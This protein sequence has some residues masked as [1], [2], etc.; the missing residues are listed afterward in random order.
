[1]EALRYEIDEKGT[2]YYIIDK[3]G[4]K[5]LYQYPPYI[6]YEK[7]T[8]EES[9]QAHIE[10]MEREAQVAEQERITIEDLQ[11]QITELKKTNEELKSINSEQDAL[12]AELV[13]I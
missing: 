4:K 1:M 7:G 9:A 3:Y 5:L 8:I 11:N 6:P 13:M 10:E 12:L 2:G